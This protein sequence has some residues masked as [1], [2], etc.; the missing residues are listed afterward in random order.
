MTTVIDVREE[1]NGKQEYAV[2]ICT[3]TDWKICVMCYC[4]MGCELKEKN[5]IGLYEAAKSD[6]MDLMKWI[7]NK[8]LKIEPPRD[9][10]AEME[11]EKNRREFDRLSG[12]NIERMPDISEFRIIKKYKE[13]VV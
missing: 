6:K 7:K 13:G 10:A 12:K 5:R 4:F 11:E 3:C 8:V 9:I 2:K 1:T